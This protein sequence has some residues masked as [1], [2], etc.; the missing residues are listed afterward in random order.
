MPIDGG[1][2]LQ[3]LKYIDGAWS[4]GMH[5]GGGGR[6][7][8]CSPAGLKSLKLFVFPFGNHHHFLK[9]HSKN[10]PSLLSLLNVIIFLRSA[11]SGGTLAGGM[12]NLFHD[13]GQH[14]KRNVQ[15]GLHTSPALA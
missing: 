5:G 2:S 3:L 6:R 1:R 14:R 9:G 13:L 4:L 7:Y 11:R 12:Q 15:N 10:A 8:G